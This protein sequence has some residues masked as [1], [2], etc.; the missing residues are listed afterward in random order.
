MRS[1]AVSPEA[2]KMLRNSRGERL[3]AR[4]CFA[5][6]TTTQHRGGGPLA[7][8]HSPAQKKTLSPATFSAG[9]SRHACFASLKSLWRSSAMAASCRRRASSSCRSC[10]RAA[11]TSARS[12]EK[13]SADL[14]L[15]MRPAYE[16]AAAASGTRRMA[17]GRRLLL[18]ASHALS[19]CRSTAL[20]T[21]WPC[22]GHGRRECVS[23]ALVRETRAHRMSCP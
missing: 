16:R 9:R 15:I 21:A 23:T 11:L 12:A 3:H 4:S 22:A 20:T 13:L 6:S 14:L 17:M 18:D 19:R 1:P 8:N 10:A 5:P 2:R 7:S